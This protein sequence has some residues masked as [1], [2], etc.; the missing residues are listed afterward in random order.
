MTMS[1]LSAKIWSKNAKRVN[2]QLEIGGCKASDLVAKYGSPIFIFD[3]DD[4]R[5][6]AINWKSE[7]SKAF[8][9][10]HGS[11]IYAAKAF[12]C[13]EVAKIIDELGIGLDVCTG[14]ELAVAK[15]AKF[16]PNRIEMHGNNKSEREIAA[17]MEYGVGRI[18]VDSMQ[19]I[20][21]VARLAKERNHVQEILIRLTPGVEA[22]THEYISTAHE[23]VK[24]GFSIASGAAWRAV[25]DIEAATSLKLTGVHAHIGSQIFNDEAFRETAS[26][27]IDFMGRFAKEFHRELLDLNLGGGFGVPYIDSDNP[28]TPAEM[29]SQISNVVIQESKK[30]NISVPRIS[31]EPGRAIAGPSM[32]TIY[33]V[34]TTKEVEL[35]NGKFRLYVAVDGG[36]SDNIRTALYGAQYIAEIASRR[37]V[38]KSR[39]CRVVGKH[40][41]TGDILINSIELPSDISPGDLLAIPVTGA[42]GRSMASNYNHVPR[43]GVISVVNG[44]A[45]T[46][47]RSE[48]EADLLALEVS[49]SANPIGEQK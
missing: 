1:E 27:L 39:D 4:F 41:E 36:M 21:R 34:G 17:A 19:E 22:H 40:C 49:E 8:T 28:I 48:T 32:T 25:T 24:F 30:V 15:A 35:E 42:Y 23:D 45:R 5:T 44:S 14:G 38:S 6:R 46:I 37:S 2:E 3:E 11:V 43:P 16:P 10:N 20:E 13:V 18:V 33:T 31:I 7:L 29:L 47:I 12:L 9:A 26:R